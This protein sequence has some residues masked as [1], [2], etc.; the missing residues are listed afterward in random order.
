MKR[1]TFFKIV[2]Y[3]LDSWIWEIL[4]E[5]VLDQYNTTLHIEIWLI[6]MI[7]RVTYKVHLVYAIENGKKIFADVIVF[8]IQQ[9]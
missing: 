4:F 6:I 9:N 1:V 5:S 7:K 8:D 3:E 2:K